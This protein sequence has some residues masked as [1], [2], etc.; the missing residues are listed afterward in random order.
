MSWQ[1][2]C[3]LAAAL[4]DDSAFAAVATSMKEAVAGHGRVPPDPDGP[5][6]IYGEL[7]PHRARPVLDIL[8]GRLGLD[9]LAG[10]EVAD[11]GCGYGALSVYFAW[12][13]AQVTGVDKSGARLGVGRGVATEHELGV[14]F[15]KGRLEKLPLPDASADAAVLNNA[16]CYVVDRDLRQRVLAEARRILRP[17]GVLAVRDPSR[18]H[19]R[20]S[21]S[22]LPLV[23]TLPPA[24]AVSVSRMFGRPRSQVRLLTARSGVKELRTAGFA[25]VAHER[26]Q[27]RPALAGLPRYHHLSGRSPGGA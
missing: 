18:T 5:L 6:R 14:R 12:H 17:G 24:L 15:R 9:S 4:G 3:D 23:G 19:P 13:G 2:G 21:F 8:T 22:G 27:D 11:L 1:S 7:I 26:P 25:D 10:L 20:D 16:L